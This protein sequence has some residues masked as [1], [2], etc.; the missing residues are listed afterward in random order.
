MSVAAASVW[1][2]SH[3]SCSK[4][5]VE[6]RQITNRTYQ[7]SS[8]L[9]NAAQ[10]LLL[11]SQ[12]SFNKAGIRQLKSVRL[13]HG[14]RL[15]C[16]ALYADIPL[17]RKCENI[18][19]ATLVWRAIKLPMYSVALIPLTVGSAAAYWQTGH[20]CA[21]R[22]LTLLV[23]SVLVIAWLN[24]SNDVHDFDKGAD[25]NKKESVVNLVGSRTGTHIV[26]CLL[27]ALGLIGLTR[28]SIEAGSL[29]SVLLLV[30]AIFCG[31]IY[32]CPPFR[33]GYVGL[34]EPLCFAAFGPFATTAFYLLQS[35][36]REL[37][38]SATA[39]SSSLLVGFTT[40]LILF[41]SHF[42]QVDDDKAIGKY[43]PLVRLGNDV[44]A[45]VVKMAVT[46]LYSLLLA[47]GLGQALP[48][49]CVVLGALTFPIGK[50]VSSFVEKN[51]K[52]KSTIF[53][54]K[55]YCVRL[56][57][58]FGLA[59]AAGLVA[60]RLFVRKQLPHAIII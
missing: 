60:A 5:L 23:S 52:D 43:S 34:G 38:I 27:L 13:R 55:Y 3:V 40:T 4:K 32:Q 58:A 22:Y 6:F 35:G 8:C 16:E 30:Y 12:M 28:V 10:R 29:R 24:L 50:L 21:K 53:L 31:Y 18:S 11:C 14:F 45:K 51:H 47:L 9:P 41:C 57:A 20:C 2:T 7:A 1:N 44:G 46:S 42:H 25:R 39:I 54:A 19:K 15:K 33:L 56:H 36:T 37:A 17:E 59:L 48:F 26:A 49:S